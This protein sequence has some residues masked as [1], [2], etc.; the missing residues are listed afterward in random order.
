MRKIFALIILAVAVA[1]VVF[2]QPSPQ[3]EGPLD[4]PKVLQFWGIYDVPEVYQPIFDQFQK[5]HPGLEIRYKQFANQEEYHQLTLQQLG[6]GKGPDIVLFD[7]DHFTDYQPHLAPASADYAEGFAKL[8]QERLI[9]RGLLYGLPLW[10]DSLMMYYNKR[11]YRDG[12][13][14][15][16]YDFAEQTKK[17]SISGVAMGRLDNLKSG[18]DIL[19][20]LFLQKDVKLSGKPEN[21]LYD[22]LEF[23]IRF[24]YP[25]DRYY[26]WNE[27]LTRNDPDLEIESFARERVAAIAGYSS[28]FHFL[29]TKSQQLEASGQRA[30]SGDEIGVA[31]FPQFTPD[32]PTYLG[33]YMALG[34]SLRSKDPNLAWELI[35]LITDEKNSL[36]YHE[37]TG[38]IPGRILPLN[39][40]DSELVKVQKQQLPFLSV[41]SIAPATMEK[42]Q[43]I[44]Q[45]SLKD[46]RVLQE[47]LEEE[48]L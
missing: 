33:K 6:K 30:I 41:L 36:Y 46:K 34:V 20:T 35:R 22:T 1:Y 40:G 38:R 4:S 32:T 47:I 10:T 12:L 7:E 27:R 15:A 25:V 16:W 5:D 3:G 24:A 17:I 29:T 21:S 8:T 45:R 31:L 18:W 37:A 11:S 28:L 48:L 9:N 39:A 26:N 2:R 13:K 43:A 14:H 42:I 23:F 44:V 19:K